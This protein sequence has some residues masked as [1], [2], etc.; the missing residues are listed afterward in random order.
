MCQV[1]GKLRK[2]L[3]CLV[4]ILSKRISAF[5]YGGAQDNE[6]KEDSVH[7]IELLRGAND[8]FR[9]APTLCKW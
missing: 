7:Q 4:S 1:K 2:A 6:V 8:Y 5:I 3:A 9:G